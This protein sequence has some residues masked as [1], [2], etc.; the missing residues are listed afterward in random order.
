MWVYLSYV[1]ADT[2][3]WTILKPCGQHKLLFFPSQSV[4]CQ[5]FPNLKKSLPLTSWTKIP[6]IMF[7][8]VWV[9]LVKLGSLFQHINLRSSVNFVKSSPY[10]HSF[11]CLNMKLLILQIFMGCTS[12]GKHSITEIPLEQLI[13]NSSWPQG[14]YPKPTIKMS[15]RCWWNKISYERENS[16]SFI[17]WGYIQNQSVIS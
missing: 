10:V 1:V 7:I 3:Y 17:I 2:R 14:A 13:I 9:Y 12:C 5:V 16:D 8:T 11:N 6:D 15:K 4:S